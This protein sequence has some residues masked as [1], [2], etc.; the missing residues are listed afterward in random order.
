MG[1]PHKGKR[2]FIGCRLPED[3]VGHVKTYAQNRRISVSEAM[4]DLAATA[5]GEPLPSET[6]PQPKSRKQPE[7]P[8]AMTA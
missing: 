7:L 8:L 4:A 3:L 1:Q 2:Q 6:L 5:L